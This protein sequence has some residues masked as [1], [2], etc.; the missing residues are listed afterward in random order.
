ME[1]LAEFFRSKISETDIFCLTE[2]N[3]EILEPLKVIFDG[4]EPFYSEITNTDYL[5]GGVEGQGIFVKKGIEVNTYKKHFIYPVNFQDA[6]ILETAIVKIDNKELMLGSVHAM[7]KPGTKN[8]TPLRIKQSEN[9][10]NAFKSW[11][12][13]VVLGGDFN[14]NP[15]TESVSV[16]EKSGYTNL[17][18][19]YE[20]KDTRGPINRDIYKDSKEGV[21]NFADYAFVNNK[22]SIKSFSVPQL[23]ASDHLPLILDISITNS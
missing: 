13:P 8:D 20:V 14:L 7:A 11:V 19:Q 5:N 12:G 4:Y 2:V 21:Q 15:D 23:E 10:L 9:I 1:K 16:F 22:V 17:I 6:G 3:P 18:K